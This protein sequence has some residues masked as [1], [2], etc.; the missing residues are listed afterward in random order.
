MGAWGYRVLENDEVLDTLARIDTLLDEEGEFRKSSCV[1]E[2]SLFSDV[3][4]MLASKD[5]H[6]KLLGVCLVDNAVNSPDYNLISSN[7]ESCYNHRTFFDV[8]SQMKSLSM[9]KEEALKAVNELIDEGAPT[10]GNSKDRLEIYYVFRHRL[11]EAMGDTDVE[12]NS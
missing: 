3:K 9:L 4:T 2:S 10:W 7:A 1:V 6:N 8:A 5:E 11:K 12:I